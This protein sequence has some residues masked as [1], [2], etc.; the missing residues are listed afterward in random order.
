MG[1]HEIMICLGSSCFLRGNKE[2]LKI[3][4]EYI[5]EKHL[6]AKIKFKGQLCSSMCNKGP[7]VII[8]NQVYENV[9]KDNI[10]QLLDKILLT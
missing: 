6:S 8:D 7:I 10:I 9:S 2:T 5:V 3:I 1:E 4:K